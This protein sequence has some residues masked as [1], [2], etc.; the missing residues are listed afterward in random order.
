VLIDMHAHYPMHLHGGAHA[1]IAFGRWLAESAREDFVDLV[2]RHF[3]YQGPGDSPSVSMELIRKG[4]VGVV[5]SVLY[6]PFDEITPKIA[7]GQTPSRDGPG[8]LRDQLQL[9]E[10]D[11]AGRADAALIVRSRADLELALSTGRT[12]VVHCVEGGFAL[13]ADVA[14]VELTVAELAGRGVAYVTLAHLFWRKVA[15]NAPALPFLS[16]DEYHAFFPQPADEGLAPLGIAAIDALIA[17]RIVI[18]LTHMTELSRNQTL[19]RVEALTPARG[20]DDV[21]V[22]ASHAACRLAGDLEYNLTDDS[23]NRIADAGGVIG[24]ILGTHYVADGETQPAGLEDSLE[25]L[26]RHV[27]RIVELRNGSFDSIAIGS[28][29]DG[30][31]K[32]ALPGLESIDKL[33]DLELGLI[34]RYGPDNAAQICSGNALRML[35]YRFASA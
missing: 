1:G 7:F 16:D 13:G 23:V 8:H 6:W 15:T 25:A 9:V 4:G 20:S 35:R 3:N 19:A 5:L 21:P 30:Y 17:Q 22:I 26:Y 12:G 11:I 32:P 29:L 33:R 2:S 24:L 18:D 34:A 31:I 28:D 14:Q 10:D 27:D